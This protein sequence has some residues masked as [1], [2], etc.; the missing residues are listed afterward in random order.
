MEETGK[1]STGITL[2]GKLE[3]AERFGMQIAIIGMG[4]ETGLH[5]AMVHALSMK[6][7][8]VMMV[9]FEDLPEADQKKLLD[10]EETRKEPSPFECPPIKII[11][12]RAHPSFDDE[13]QISLN[14]KQFAGF[15]HKKLKGYQKRK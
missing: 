9:K 10:A 8:K 6:P 13:I 15:K 14:P 1:T 2:S 12:L 4:A 3:E 7:D 11:E 5:A